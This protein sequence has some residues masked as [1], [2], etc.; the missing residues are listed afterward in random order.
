[1]ISSRD[2]LRE[3]IDEFGGRGIALSDRG[4]PFTDLTKTFLRAFGSPNYFDHDATCGA[5]AHHAA[6]SLLGVGRSSI[7][8]D[9]RRARHIVLYGRNIIESLKVKEAKEFMA[10]LA[11]GARCT[12]IDPRASFT[13]A[14][15][16]RY[17]Q[18]RPNSDYALNLAIIHEVLRL[19]V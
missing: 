14:K 5:N 18:V 10:A 13:A 11:G 8:F 4:G 19:E 17:W 1:M 12:Y 15:A 3:V 6:L 2:R 9:Y 16:T 7:G